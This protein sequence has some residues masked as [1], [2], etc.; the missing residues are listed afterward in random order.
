MGRDLKSYQQ[1]V[2][3][4]KWSHPPHPGTDEALPLSVIPRLSAG[5]WG[6]TRQLHKT[7]IKTSTNTLALYRKLASPQSA[8]LWTTA[9]LEP[10][11]DLLQGHMGVEASWHV[12]GDLGT[13][14]PLDGLQS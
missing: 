7:G 9:V 2:T 14:A 5:S 4:P 3:Q 6:S 10:F 13:G 1:G 11:I 12:G 8:P